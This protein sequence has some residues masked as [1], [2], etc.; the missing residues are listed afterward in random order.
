MRSILFYLFALVIASGAEAQSLST[1]F[2]QKHAALDVLQEQ[3]KALSVYGALVKQGYAVA[4]KGLSAISKHKAGDVDTHMRYLLGWKRIDTTVSG[5]WKSKDIIVMNSSI[6]AS[7]TGMVQKA[8]EDGHLSPDEK[9]VVQT[10]AKKLAASS[11]NLIIQLQR[12]TT[13]GLFVI[14]EQERKIRIDKL[15]EQMKRTYRIAIQFAAGIMILSSQK[16][17][18][19]EE[20]QIFKSLYKNKQETN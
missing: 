5:Y 16:K 8:L 9:N 7:A 3:V 2:A 17:K 13:D 15:H 1:W 12:I 18:Q 10:V 4:E 14:K 11:S 6:Q 19:S 20:V